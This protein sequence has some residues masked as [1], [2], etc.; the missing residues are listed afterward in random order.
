VQG[1][2]F[3][4]FVQ[5][6]A[7]ELGLAGFVRNRAG[8]VHGEAEG[9]RSALDDFELM[10]RKRAPPLAAVRG[11]RSERV[12]LR[13]EPGFAITASEHSADPRPF[14]ASDVAVCE[15]CLRELF[16][17]HDRRFRYPFLNCTDCGPRLTIVLSAPYDRERTTMRDFA[18]CA[19]CRAEYSD[20]SS[21]RFHA[22]PIACAECGP[23]L[24]LL[25]QMGNPLAQEQ[26]LLAAARAL[27]AEQI[28]AIKGIGGFHLACL[29][30]SERATAELRRR[31]QRDEKPFAILVRDTPS[32]LRLCELEPAEIALLESAERPIVLARRRAGARVSHAVAGHSPLLGVMLA[33][34]PLHHLLCEALDDAPLVMTSGNASHEP[35]AFEEADARARLLPLSDRFLTHNR[36]IH[37]RCDD[38]VLRWSHG[39]RS[40][41]RRARG[42]APRPTPL[43]SEL[44]RPLLALGAQ[45][46]ATFALGRGDHALVSH[47]LGDLANAAALCGYRAALDHYEQLFAVKPELLV[48]DLHPDYASTQLAQELAAERGLPRMAVQ[49]HHAHIVSCM[50]EHGL[51]GPLLGVAWDGTGYGEDGT[52][53]GGELLLCDRR[54][55]RRAAH[56]RAVPMP[57][58]ESAIREPWRMALAYLRDAGLDPDILAGRVDRRAE[59]VISRML[60]RDFNCP[61]T[62]SA[63]RLFDAVSALCGVRHSSSYEGQAAVELEWAA[64]R[65]VAPDDR[66]AYPYELEARRAER[67]TVVDTRPLIRAI[68]AELRRG[69]KAP[70]VARRFHATLGAI[71]AE[72]CV[73]LGARHGLNRVVL[74]GGVFA[75]AL[76][77]Q[78]VEE[79]LTAANLR[80]FR[81]Q[82]YPAGDGGLCLGQLAIAAARDQGAR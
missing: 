82:M 61:R 42:L 30:S 20:P 9:A 48:H 53:W 46:N 8:E 62:S 18:L 55:A 27:R 73:D 7:S 16:A 69:T 10:L 28:V 32:A 60:E 45:D 13:G 37:L 57:G 39:A 58:G 23:R 65:A 29:A 76:L 71:I 66:R 43:G 59:R 49:H 35:I 74:A 38:S 51:E 47:H 31:K 81:P 36:A 70:S 1:V 34:T 41:L 56:L 54:S 11:V 5:R 33:Y 4:P 22:E 21:R 72:L 64:T 80:V 17:E 68:V 77:L 52:I 15:P 6:L 79:R 50:V 12:E 24:E 63:G 78:E 14:F 3:R 25:D 40:T 2:G 67:P 19:A 44:R 26:P 75:N